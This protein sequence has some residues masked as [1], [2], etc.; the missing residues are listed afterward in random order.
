MS[1]LLPMLPLMLQ[2]LRKSHRQCQQ[3]PHSRLQ[4]TRN[5]TQKDARGRWHTAHV[6]AGATSFFAGGGAATGAGAGIDTD[7]AGA[8][9]LVERLARL[10]FRQSH[11]AWNSL[12]QTPACQRRAHASQ[13]QRRRSAQV[14]SKRVGDTSTVPLRRGP[15]LRSQQTPLSTAGTPEPTRSTPSTCALEGSTDYTRFVTVCRWGTVRR[16]IPHPL[17]SS[18]L[19]A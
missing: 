15:C 7:C 18:P 11:G 10:S 17:I 13:C 19:A 2:P 6:G 4:A 8:G 14:S 9:R 5:L 16:M 12:C 3:S 1:P